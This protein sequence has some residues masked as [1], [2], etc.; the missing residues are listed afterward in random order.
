MDI[1][2]TSA[3]VEVLN[4]STPSNLTEVLLSGSSVKFAD[5]QTFLFGGGLDGSTDLVPDGNAVSHVSSDA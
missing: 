3:A 4:G 1:D 2:G 5:G